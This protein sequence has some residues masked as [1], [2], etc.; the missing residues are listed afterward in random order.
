M[1]PN[2]LLVPLLALFLPAACASAA[3]QTF[4][5]KASAGGASA[6][7]AAKRFVGSARCQR[8]HAEEFR[9]WKETFHARMV[10]PKD[11][12][13][14]KGVVEKWATDGSRPGPTTG[15]GTGK[16]YTLDD[17]QYVIGSKWKQRFLVKNEDTGGLQ[18]LNKQFNRDSG[19]WEDYDNRNDWDTTCAACHTTGYRITSY[20]PEKPEAQQVEWAELGI[21]CEACHGPGAAHV[22]S[23]KKGDIWTAGG[24]S[25]EV[26]SRLC[27]YCHVRVKNERYR[28]AQGNPREDLPAPRIGDTFTPS[29]D[30]RKWYPEHVVM[31]GI[32]AEDPVD[33]DY[34]RDL[35]GLFKVDALSKADG[36]YEEA[37]HRQEYQGF[38]QSAHYKKGGISCITCHSPHAGKGKIEKVARDACVSCHDA[39][40]TP[41]K[42]MPNTGKTADDLFV[43]THTFKA[44][45]RESSGSGATGEPE[46]YKD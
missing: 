23:R 33:K 24:R 38:I 27:G 18:F 39:S 15:N 36:V 9:S 8:C 31:P 19:K 29:A 45:P 20:D 46:Y 10:R 44:K 3:E 41:E 30:W 43:K 32:Q 6:R 11:E 12:G 35:E 16:A 7:S 1:R 4:A 5:P 26:Q 2:A 14:L 40:Y 37:K 13:I 34:P 21:G 25:A 42:Y 28:N 17:V 22:R